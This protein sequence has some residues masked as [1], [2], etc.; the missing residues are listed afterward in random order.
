MRWLEALGKLSSS[1]S[2][3]GKKVSNSRSRCI[4]DQNIKVTPMQFTVGHAIV[5]LLVLLKESRHLFLFV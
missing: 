3:I 1:H 4:F 5:A 2:L